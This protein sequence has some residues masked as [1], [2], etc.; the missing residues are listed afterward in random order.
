MGQEVFHV[1]VLSDAT[2]EQQANFSLKL[3]QLKKIIRHG[4]KA[5]EGS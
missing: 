1:P 5:P 4:R 2:A 3:Q